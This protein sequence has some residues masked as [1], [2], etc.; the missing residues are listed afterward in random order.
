[1]RSSL[2]FACRF[3][4]V[5]ILFEKHKVLRF[6]ISVESSEGGVVLYGTTLVFNAHKKKK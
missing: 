1:M 2:V 6:G 3:S 4:I 5:Q